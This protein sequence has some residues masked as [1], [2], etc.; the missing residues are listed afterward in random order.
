MDSFDSNFIFQEDR[1]CYVLEKSDRIVVS[2][3]KTTQGLQG[4]KCELL[5][6]TPL[7]YPNSF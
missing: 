5:H 1:F 7:K 3:P 6:S 2:E 4:T